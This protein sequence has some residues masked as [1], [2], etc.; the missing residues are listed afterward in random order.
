[1]SGELLSC[2]AKSNLVAIVEELTNRTGGGLQPKD[3]TND[4]APLPPKKVAVLG[5]TV[6]VQTRVSHHGSRHVP[7][8]LTTSAALDSTCS[9]HDEVHLVFAYCDLLTS[10]KEATQERPQGG[11]PA[12]ALLSYGR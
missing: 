5:G 12:T 8:G 11:K 7:N 9:D 6:V 2:T 3:V 1:M 4:V 10:L